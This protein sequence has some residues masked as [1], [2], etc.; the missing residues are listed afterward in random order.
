MK[1]P[2]KTATTNATIE[3]KTKQKYEEGGC[4]EYC[5]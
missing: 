1:K 2:A 3:K 4:T 5:G